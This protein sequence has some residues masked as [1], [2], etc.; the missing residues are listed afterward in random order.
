LS[1]ISLSL[2][3]ILG[4]LVHC[5]IEPVMEQMGGVHTK[6]TR[7]NFKENKSRGFVI[8]QLLL[9]SIVWGIFSR[10]QQLICVDG[11]VLAMTLCPVPVPQLI[12]LTSATLHDHHSSDQPASCLAPI[13]IAF[14]GSLSATLSVSFF[15][16]Y[17]LD[18]SYLC[19]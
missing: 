11:R 12:N 5:S 3:A 1:H 17:W 14:C 8:T 2:V 16:C 4:L 10:H 19:P 13:I 6:S 18:S 15:C 9:S 7:L